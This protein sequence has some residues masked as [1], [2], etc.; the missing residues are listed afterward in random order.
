MLPTAVDMAMLCERK[1]K[2]K[3]KVVSSFMTPSGYNF[4]FLSCVLFFAP[5]SPLLVWEWTFEIRFVWI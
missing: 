4:E 3:L 1:E 2:K 5:H